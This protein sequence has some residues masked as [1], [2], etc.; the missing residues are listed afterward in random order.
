[1]TVAIIGDTGCRAS[2]KQT[3]NEDQWPFANVVGDLAPTPALATTDL[4]VHMGD[5]MYVKFDAWDVWKAEFFDVASPLLAS[6]AWL[7]VRGNHER[8]GKFGDAP[9]GFYLFFDVGDETLNCK[10]GQEANDGQ[11]TETYAVDLSSDRRIIVSDSATAF[12][13]NTDNPSKDNESYGQ[14]LAMLEGGRSLSDGVKEKSV[15]FATHVPVYALEKCDGTTCSSDPASATMRAAWY[16]S[17][18]TPPR[19][20]AILSGHAHLFEV[21]KA[22]DQPLQVVSGAGGVELDPPPSALVNSARCVDAKSL[23][24]TQSPSVTL[25]TYAAANAQVDLK[26]CSNTSFGYVMAVKNDFSFVPVP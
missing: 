9:L 25:P 10:D 5:F 13:N 6:A 15:W 11:L 14:M 20:D 18:K 4:V 23:A 3:C 2:N 21:L 8:C 12:T 19:V 22:P 24:S 1:V 16:A 26:A 17:G 7:M